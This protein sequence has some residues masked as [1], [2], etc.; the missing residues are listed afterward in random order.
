VGWNRLLWSM[1]SNGNRSSSTIRP[2]LHPARLLE[3]KIIVQ[4]RRRTLC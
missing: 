4:P 2:R 1:I 3:D